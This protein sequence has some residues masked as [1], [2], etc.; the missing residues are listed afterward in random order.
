[1]RAAVY[2]RQSRD[3]DKDGNQTGLA[4]A[5]QR[6]DCLKL[7]RERGWE[8]TE[9]V[10][11]DVSAYSGKRRPN[12]E[13]MLTDIQAGKLDAVVVWDLDR[14]HRRPIELESF[15]QLADRHRIALAT[16]SGDTDLSTDSG[17]LF[18]RI[19]GAVA[20]A[21]G[22]RKSA[23]QKRAALQ[24]AQLG[25]PAKG[26]RA[27]GY[28]GDGIT[29]RENEANALRN[30]YASLLAGRSMVGIAK[31]FDAAGFLTGRLGK[32]FNHSAARAVLVNPRNA[33]LRAYR[34]EI[35]GPAAWPAIVD[36]DTWRAAHAILTDSGRRRGPGSSARKWLL[37]GLA[38]CGRCDDGETT[39]K[40]TYRGERDR[41]GKLV[42]AY[43]CS[44]SSHLTREASFCDWRVSERVIYRL[45][46]SDAQDLLIDDDREDL[47][48]LRTEQSTLRLR[49]DQLAEQ[50]ADGALG[51]SQLRAG[52]ERLRTRL[53]DLESRMVHI[54][55]A[56]LLADLVTADDVRKAWEKLSLDR[57]RAVID[58]L[59]TVT[60]LS[61]PPGRKPAAR[62]SVRMVPKT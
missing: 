23:R 47:A 9:Y 32:P 13:R 54:D 3:R 58:L 43:R 11:N 8:P 48:E 7:C 45:S 29:V 62:E 59:Y 17:R 39:V 22:E 24:K 20:R 42:R 50:F 28:E 44:K 36:E 51:A 55:R 12:Y 56:P 49:L 4:V 2:L 31:D 33:G 16:V 6:E 27:F 46:R 18:A 61:R 14:L 30:A 5:R 37:G 19:K 21:E 60:L 52:T 38:L 1:M 25:Q 35:V 15:M 34:G 40:V 53:A 57:Q 41:D 26:P 10:D